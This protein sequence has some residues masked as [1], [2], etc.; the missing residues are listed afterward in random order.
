MFMDLSTASKHLETPLK[1]KLLEEE[2]D[3]S[4]ACKMC[5]RSFYLLSLL[6][7]L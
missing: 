4:E 3:V 1:A 7:L 2:E 6:L 5:L